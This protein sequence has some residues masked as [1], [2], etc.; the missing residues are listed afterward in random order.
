[1][2]LYQ[3]EKLMEET[4]RLAAEYR[5]TTGQTLPVGPD[6]AR[7]DAIRLL[8]L[9]EATEETKGI[10]AHDADGNGVQIKS[11]VVFDSRK[12]GHRIGQLNTGADWQKLVL[13]I[14]DDNY[15]PDEIYQ[16]DRG[17][18]LQALEQSENSSQKKRGAMSLARFRV[19]AELVWERQQGV[20]VD[21]YRA[22]KPAG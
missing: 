16:M 1:M 11:R 10:D 8:G 17:T 5:R 21:E 12:T 13:V 18:A 22:D 15:Q 9:T 20:L 3:L 2:A 6:L 19:M 14:M 7:Y 4:R